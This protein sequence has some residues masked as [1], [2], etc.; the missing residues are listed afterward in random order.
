MVQLLFVCNHII[1]CKRGPHTHLDDGKRRLGCQWNQWKH[2]MSCSKPDNNKGSTGK[3]PQTS[4]KSDETLATR[5]PGAS[6]FCSKVEDP[7]V[8]S[9]KAKS[10]ETLKWHEYNLPDQSSRHLDRRLS[11]ID[12]TQDELNNAQITPFPTE[13]GLVQRVE[14]TTGDQAPITMEAAKIKMA[15]R[16]KSS[17]T[18]ERQANVTDTLEANVTDALEANATDALK[19]TSSFDD[20]LP[21]HSLRDVVLCYSGQLRGFGKVGNVLENHLEAFIE[22]LSKRPL[23][24]RVQVVFIL[25]YGEK[26]DGDIANRYRK[27]GV[28]AVHTEAMPTDYRSGDHPMFRSIKFGGSV[29]KKLEVQQGRAFDFG[30]RIRYDVSFLAGKGGAIVFGNLVPMWPIWNVSSAAPTL[31]LF[32]K[33]NPSRPRAQQECLPQDVFFVSKSQ[34]ESPGTGPMTSGWLFSGNHSIGQKWTADQ[35]DH[36]EAM[37][38]VDAVRRKSRVATVISCGGPPPCFEICRVCKYGKA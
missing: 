5:T 36:Y 29:I 26:I 18:S 35:R 7:T 15:H 23:S 25:S 30:V 4:K 38:L 21:T 16:F 1:T 6:G 27:H 31:L 34:R 12:A 32:Q 37:L 17:N 24:L 13:L 9:T 19:A 20:F 10:G 14:N 3:A 28:S 33:S 11:P 22:P 2:R 8:K